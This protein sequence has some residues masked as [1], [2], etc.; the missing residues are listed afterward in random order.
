MA[1]EKILIVDDDPDLVQALS[2]LLQ[3]E[4][5]E[6]LSA[7]SGEEGLQTARREKPAVMILDVM[8][9]GKD[10]FAVAR[11]MAADEALGQIRLI[12]LTAVAEYSDSSDYSP[13]AAI[14]ALEADEWF[15]K[16]VEPEALVNCIKDLLV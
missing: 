4:G 3:R 8:M 6:P 11:E 10:G 7:Y 12:M 16:P 1:G 9:E 5:L 13:Q 14:G 15:D 2:I